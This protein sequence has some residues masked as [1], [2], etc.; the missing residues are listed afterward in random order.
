[1]RPSTRL[2]RN[3]GTISL[4]LSSLTAFMYASS[5]AYIL[6]SRTE[7]KRSVRRFSRSSRH[8]IMRL[9]M[10]FCSLDVGKGKVRVINSHAAQQSA[11]PVPT[12]AARR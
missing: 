7:D 10:A 4:S 5:Q 8:F 1:M 2:T 9:Q 6:T 11:G 3:T 12:R